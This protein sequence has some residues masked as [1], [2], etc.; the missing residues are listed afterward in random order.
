[1]AK[2]NHRVPLRSTDDA[3]TISDVYYALG[4]AIVVGI[5]NSQTSKTPIDLT[6]TLEDGTECTFCFAM[7]NTIR[8]SG[9]NYVLEAD[10]R[11][12][13]LLSE[14]DAETESELSAETET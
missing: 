2:K 11:L 5:A 7:E 1:M 4:D 13:K 8:L 12:W 3:E 6:F 10:G 14:A 9:Q